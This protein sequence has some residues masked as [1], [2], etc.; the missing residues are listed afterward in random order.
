MKKID[1]AYIFLLPWMIGFVF[2][3]GGPIL[4]SFYLSFTRWNLL[5]SPKFIGLENFK[6]LFTSGSEFY[7]SL[8]I[9]LIFT[10]LS[11]LISVTTSLLLALLLNFKVRFIRVFQFFYFV[12][13]VMPSVVI[14]TVFKLM[15]NKEIGVINYFLSFLG[16]SA[17]N[18]LNDSEIVLGSLATISI[19][20][21]STGQM[22]MIFNSSLKEVPKELYE[23]SDIE[24]AN[25]FQRFIYVTL[26]SISPIILFNVVMSTISS[27]NSSFTLIYPLTGGGPG[28]TTEV[29]GLSI[30]RN[31]FKLFNMGYASSIAL[32]LFIVVAIISFV[33]FRL[34]KDLVHYN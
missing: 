19:F 14:A 30:Y 26:P 4:Y 17:I 34:S 15:L 8:K 32:I 22:M 3:S 13:A 16:I 11:V 33:Q 23:A 28:K 12:P 31:A 21:F 10:I 1:S 29:L 6:V 7:S 20:T 2:F 9:T 25:F 27:L 5:G 18:W 24:G